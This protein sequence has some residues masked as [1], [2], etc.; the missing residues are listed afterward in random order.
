MRTMSRLGMLSGVVGVC[1]GAA[2]AGEPPAGEPATPESK[3]LLPVPDYSGD[4]ATRRF[5]SGDWGGTRGQLAGKG[6]SFAVD[7]TQVT[8]GVVQGG[9]RIDWDYVGSLD[10]IMVADLYRM[11]V[12]PG[13]MLKVRAESRYGETVNDDTGSVLAVN[14]DG[15]V[16]ITSPINEGLPIAVTELNYTQFL[17]ES[18]AVLV[19]KVQTLDGDPNEFASGRGRSQFMNANFVY[20]AVGARTVPYST[21]GVGVVWLPTSRVTVASSLINTK[22]SS[23]T[24]GFDHIADG[25]TWTAEV[26]LQ[27]RLGSLPG[28]FNLGGTYAFAGDFSQIGG[29]LTL[30]PSVSI[31]KSSESWAIYAS[32]WQFLFTPDQAPE[33]LDGTNGR[34]DVRGLGVFAR[35]GYGD[36]D[37]NPV[38]WTGSFG[39]GGRGLVL[40]RDD[41]TWGVG[42]YYT[43][44][45]DFRRVLKVADS[46]SGLEAFYNVAITP[47]VGLT[48]DVQWADGGFETVDAA[49]VVGARLDMRF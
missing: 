26:D 5:L 24:T 39:L 40:D 6:L 13:A 41:D 17:S 18:F 31:E 36:P 7:W 14:T 1:A 22:D 28:G 12:V 48:F 2:C 29:K 27:Y 30:L 8:Q 16:P 46:S 32:A 9:E 10:Y 38:D 34:P 25:W 33:K 4:L 3:G 11:G 21:L 23:T 37:T 42:A 49:T 44:L 47:A 35:L 19:G 15:S 45:Q 43:H 20:N